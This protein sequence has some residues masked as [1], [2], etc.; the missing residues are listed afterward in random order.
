MLLTFLFIIIIFML[1]KF[2]NLSNLL[3]DF[4]V[5]SEEK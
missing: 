5:L 3:N 2:S 1:H 4:R